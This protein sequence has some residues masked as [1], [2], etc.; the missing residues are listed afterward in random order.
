MLLL[1]SDSGLNRSN[2]FVNLYIFLEDNHPKNGSFKFI[3][4]TDFPAVKLMWVIMYAY[5]LLFAS[6]FLEVGVECSKVKD[7][8]VGK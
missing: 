1:F 5:Q 7:S 3:I 6:W 2:L 4:G 8:K